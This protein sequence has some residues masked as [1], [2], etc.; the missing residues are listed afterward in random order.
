MSELPP[1]ASEAD[2]LEQHAEVRPD[3]EEPRIIGEPGWEADPADVAEQS[4]S[5]EDDD[6]YPDPEQ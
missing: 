6:E 4:L 1:E 2:V 3:P 5:V